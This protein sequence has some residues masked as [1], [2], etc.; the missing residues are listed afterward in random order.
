MHAPIRKI[1]VSLFTIVLLS[2][3]WL[4]VSAQTNPPPPPP[5][6][7][8]TNDG[9]IQPTIDEAV[10]NQDQASLDLG[11]SAPTTFNNSG[12]FVPLVGLPGLTDE[13]AKRSL[14]D[15]LNALFRLAIGIGA[16]IA[17]IK[18][19]FAGIKYMSRD[20]FF[21]K[22][23][24]KSDIQT[25]LLGLLIMLSVVLVLTV[26]NPNL[27]NLNV[28]Q[29]LPALRPNP[30]L[31]SGTG[32]GTSSSRSGVITGCS[33]QQEQTEFFK[34]CVDGK[35]IGHDISSGGVECIGSLTNTSAAATTTVARFDAEYPAKSNTAKN[36][37]IQNVANYV[38]ANAAEIEAAWRAENPVAAGG[39]E[40]EVLYIVERPPE[41]D[42]T[43]TQTIVQ[44][45]GICADWDKGAFSQIA[46][47][48]F[49]VGGK[50]YQVC[51]RMK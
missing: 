21:A 6:G 41:L 22:E 35:Q 34:N 5:P 1:A 10:A 28:L 51:V 31:S 11:Y 45:Q 48:K 23:E 17:V 33:T 43:N 24:A 44:Q 50:Q 25:A 42:S 36:N 46:D 20:S 8:G 18:I 3:V 32:C 2:S 47:D 39:E 38:P 14:A 13:S 16:L 27:L 37:F 12:G 9:T 15:Y 40:T 4:P 49:V 7:S 29:E 19:I 30:N 26:I